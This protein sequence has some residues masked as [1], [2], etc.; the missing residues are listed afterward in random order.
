VQAVWTVD[1]E[2]MASLAA[3][4]PGLAGGWMSCWLLAFACWQHGRSASGSHDER[5]F[6]NVIALAVCRK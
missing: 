2:M 6:S 3:D 5:S 4:P 1:M